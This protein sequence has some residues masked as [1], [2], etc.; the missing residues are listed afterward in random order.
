MDE[1]AETAVGERDARASSYATTSHAG[2]P[3]G[4]VT[5]TIGPRSRSSRRSGAVCIAPG[6]SNGNFGR[7]STSTDVSV[8]AALLVVGSIGGA[9]DR[10][11]GRN[12]RLRRAPDRLFRS[13]I[14]PEVDCIAEHGE[15][16][17]GDEAALAIRNPQSPAP[18]E[19][20]ADVDLPAVAQIEAQPPKEG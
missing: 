1:V 4:V 6:R 11:E 10:P 20:A 3:V 17:A 15:R 13:A 19:R 16:D 14:D 5:R 8:I 2:S 18:G 12:L 7:V 9:K